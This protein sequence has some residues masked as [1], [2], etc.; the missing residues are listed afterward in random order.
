VTPG[1][2]LRGLPGRVG[3]LPTR[4]RRLV[5]LALVAGYVAVFYAVLV[6]VQRLIGDDPVD[7]WQ[8]LGPIVGSLV[9]TSLV[10]WWQRRQLGGR[11]RVD[12]LQA[13]LRSRRLPEDA[14]PAVWRPLLEGQRR[15][16]QGAVLATQ[17][18]L[19]VLGLAVLLLA[20]VSTGFLLG[21]LVLLVLA[22]LLTG[23]WGRRMRRGLDELIAGLPAEPA[24]QT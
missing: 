23:W 15:T 2:R 21:G 22:T 13:A 17:F 12:Q 9:G 20:D 18:L 19:V 4:R 5:L 16:Q 1:E 10:T 8:P 7:W 3:A 14:D 24:G 11:E 6:L